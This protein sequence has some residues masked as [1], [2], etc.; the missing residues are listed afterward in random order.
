MS[1]I[2][3][4]FALE[5]IRNQVEKLISP[6]LA[7]LSPPN[8]HIGTSLLFKRMY[9]V[10]VAVMFGPKNSKMQR[11]RKKVVVWL[12]KRKEKSPRE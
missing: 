9:S 8:I 4:Y 11:M 6:T 7:I 10:E 3:T 1:S 2:Y 5:R 12:D